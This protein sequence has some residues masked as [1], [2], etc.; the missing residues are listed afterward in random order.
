MR[1]LTRHYIY[2]NWLFGVL[3][4]LVESVTV[5]ENRYRTMITEM[6]DGMNVD[7]IWF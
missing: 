3:Y 4:A 2:K 5:N 7:E 6:L 1:P